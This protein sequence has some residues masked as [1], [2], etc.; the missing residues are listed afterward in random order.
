MIINKKIYNLVNSIDLSNIEIEYFDTMDSKYYELE[1]N[2]YH[3]K[4]F[5][6][7]SKQFK[8]RINNL[9][10]NSI[11]LVFENNPINELVTVLFSDKSNTLIL[12]KNEMN[13][14]DLQGVKS[15]D[16]ITVIV[17]NPFIPLEETQI[18]DDRNL[19]LKLYGIVIND[20]D[21][22]IDKW[23]LAERKSDKLFLKKSSVYL[24][25]GGDEKFIWSR[26]N[27]EL[28]LTN[29]SPYKKINI[30]IIN[31]GFINKEFKVYINE[32]FYKTFNFNN[33]NDKS[34]IISIPIH[35]DDLFIKI[36]SNPII[37]KNIHINSNDERVLGFRFNKIELSFGDFIETYSV[38]KI[39]YLTSELF[40]KCK[41]KTELKLNIKKVLNKNVAIICHVPIP[42]NYTDENEYFFKNLSK[43]TTYS[44]LIIFS[45]F[46]WP[47][48][49]RVEKPKSLL[50]QPKSKSAIWM[51]Y[52]CMEFAK[53]NDIE[54]F[55]LLESDCR[56]QKDNWDYEIFE[57]AIKSNAI[58]TGTLVF[59][60]INKTKELI[61]FAKKSNSIS[62]NGVYLSNFE[63]QSLFWTNGAF[64]TYHVPSILK[65][66]NNETNYE[67]FEKLRTYDFDPCKFIIQDL[68]IKNACKKI[69]NE[70][71]VISFIEKDLPLGDIMSMSRDNVYNCY[72]PVKTNWMPKRDVYK[73]Y[74]SGDLGDIIYSLP[75]IMLCGGGELLMG[76][77]NL[78]PLL[79]PREKMTKNKFDFLYPLLL[80]LKYISNIEYVENVNDSDI[81][82]NLNKMRTFLYD[83]SYLKQN[84]IKNL[85]ETYTQLV[86][87]KQFFN[88]ELTW[89]NVD[90]KYISKFIISRSFRY[91]DNTFPW[92]NIYEFIK[93][94]SHFIGTDD[95]YD[96][97]I[98]NFGFIPRYIVKDALDMAE[99]I[100]GCEC[101][102]GNQSFPMSIAIAQGK[103]ILQEYWPERKDCLFFRKNL[104]TKDHYSF[105]KLLL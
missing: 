83:H 79:S 20:I 34:L 26:S 7:T 105:E 64:A 99:I 90:K 60:N 22:P 96:N 92:Q 44:D 89:I 10:K 94:E 36:E 42:E 65:Y 9:Y 15:G 98:K 48:S 100:N 25:E 40:D 52:K 81:D 66:F 72:H 29:Y 103:N 24:V 63:Q 11:K 49:I 23:V 55:I 67:D 70:P 28:L 45:E 35:R 86:G 78:D 12:N 47:N 50:K 104:V 88:D 13:I 41:I 76:N 61:E 2:P 56:V 77:H 84:K 93:N 37:P 71:T 38:D 43:Y 8:F 69:L 14:V 5:K 39:K 16:V 75:S 27:L 95:E 87:V 82:Y 19:G 3:N 97:F 1:M 31:D 54:Y 4:Y 33:V 46:P 30:H 101:F 91:R 6:W 53:N 17:H 102:I 68:G 62:K 18:I 59:S 74:H 57:N 73:F 51:F 85:A 58:T 32:E 80:K 21:F